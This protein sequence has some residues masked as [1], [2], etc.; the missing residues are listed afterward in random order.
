L[1]EFGD[2][3]LVP[4]R[5]RD[6]V[7]AMQQTLAAKCIHFEPGDETA[8]IADFAFLEINRQSVVSRDFLH[9]D[10]DCRDSVVRAVCDEDVCERFGE[11][12]PEAEIAQ[13]PGGVLAR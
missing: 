8:V 10:G 3:R 6:L 4:Q 7:V 11:D 9:V 13:R 1:F 5:E 2:L 12:G